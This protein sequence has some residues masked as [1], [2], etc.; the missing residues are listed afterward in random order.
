MIYPKEEIMP[1]KTMCD[2][3][4]NY[5]V[6]YFCR[7]CKIG[8]CPECVVQHSKHDFMFADQGAAFEVKNNLKTLSLSV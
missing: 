7:D 6:R 4:P 8:C 5:P 1:L 3:H 2:L